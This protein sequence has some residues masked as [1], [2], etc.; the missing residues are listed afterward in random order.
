MQWTEIG[1]QEYILQKMQTQ[2]MDISAIGSVDKKFNRASGQSI[3]F[4]NFNTILRQTAWQRS[5]RIFDCHKNA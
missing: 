2:E 1:K 5:V 3:S 4:I